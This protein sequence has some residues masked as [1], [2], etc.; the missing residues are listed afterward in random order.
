MIRLMTMILTGMLILSLVA[1]GQREDMFDALGL[2]RVQDAR[3]LEAL[4]ETDERRSFFDRFLFRSPIGDDEADMGEDEGS[5]SRTNVQVEG[6]D[7]SDIVKTD[8]EQIY[9]IR[10]DTLT[11]IDV[12]SDGSMEVILDESYDE[13]LQGRYTELYLTDEYVVVLGMFFDQEAQ[14]STDPAM[15]IG[16]HFPRYGVYTTITLF[17]KH[18]L[19]HVDVFKV[20]GRLD[21][22]RVMED[23]LYVI[24]NHMAHRDSE[25]RRPHFHHGDETMTPEYEAITYL[26][27]MPHS[28]FT[29]ITAITLN[30]S[31]EMETEVF[32]GVGGWSAIY[33]SE[34]GIYFA[35]HYYVAPSDQRGADDDVSSD[36]GGILGRLVTYRF[37]EEGSPEYSGQ[38]HYRGRVINQFAM[39]EH[40]GV[41]RMVTT[42]GF[43]EGVVNRLY[44]FESAHDEEGKP[45]MRELAML[46]EGIGKPRETVRSVRFQGE[47]LTVVTF[48]VIDPYYVID[49]SD[50][51]NPVIEGELE[52]P[53]FSTY[54]HPWKEDTVIGI[55]Y[56]TDDQGIAV[57]LK[58][59]LFD[60]QDPTRPVEVG[61]SLVLLNEDD[62]W[63]Y[64]E[65]LYNHKAIL[66]SE[67]HDFIG[68]ALNRQ[69][70]GSHSGQGEYLI[71]SI[72]IE[73]ETP[74][75]IDRTIS[76]NDRF[77]EGDTDWYHAFS[78]NRAVIINDWLYVL[79]PGAI[80][81]H[82]IHDGFEELEAMPFNQE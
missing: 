31:P 15:D 34:K 9:Y 50:P 79:S 58:F 68:L 28:S 19:N 82:S 18:T 8:G 30:E 46:D 75:T 6:I 21:T 70:W 73:S 67:P 61:E 4:M 10:H 22:S 42:E 20:S 11:V 63:Q 74:V 43:G 47:M 78:V 76:H 14:R 17:E 54:Q 53:G 56:E 81:R 52:M 35:T 55:G 60:N 13:Y 77:E 65:A 38:G 39:D 41:L 32:L 66:V 29:V 57:G 23:T 12:Q 5:H 3:H 37:T 44:T 26:P 69:A 36:E 27:G 24:T 71:L 51:E 72:G 45:F 1:C 49:L 25:D 7:E 59:S 80:T 2:A 48:E 33:V 64:S 62:G 40:E 16:N